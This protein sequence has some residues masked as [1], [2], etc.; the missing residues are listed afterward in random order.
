MTEMDLNLRTA[1]RQHRWQRFSRIVSGSLGLAAVAGAVYLGS[2]APVTSPVSP[3][4]AVSAVDPVAAAAA[5][6]PAARPDRGPQHAPRTMTG[7]GH[8][9]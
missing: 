9:R 3:P 6:P 7:F 2:T 5:A 8:R 1:A 4:A